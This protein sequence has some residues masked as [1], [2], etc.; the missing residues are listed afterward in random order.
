MVKSKRKTCRLLKMFE[1]TTEGTMK[2]TWY[3]FFLNHSL[4]LCVQTKSTKCAH[5]DI[6]KPRAFITACGNNNTNKSAQHTRT[7]AVWRC[8]G[9]HWWLVIAQIPVYLRH[10]FHLR[11]HIYAVFLWDKIKMPLNSDG[12]LK[13]DMARRIL[14]VVL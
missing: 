9:S 13:Y 4:A 1:T 2:T 6:S 5:D 8:E 10:Y 14:C 3:L 7:R 11:S 12:E